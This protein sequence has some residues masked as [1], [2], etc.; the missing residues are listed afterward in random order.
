[1]CVVCVYTYMK[2][3]NQK[4]LFLNIKNEVQ[5]SRNEFGM[6]AGLYGS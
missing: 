2:S 6:F 3:F 5:K 4:F 1:M